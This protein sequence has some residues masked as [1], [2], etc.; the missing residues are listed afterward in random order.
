LLPG[1]AFL[2]T[3]HPFL[4]ALPPLVVVHA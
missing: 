3:R 1:P 4:L 2:V